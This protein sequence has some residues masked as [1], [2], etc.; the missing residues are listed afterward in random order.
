MDAIWRNPT[1]VPPPVK[2]TT[3]QIISDIPPKKRAAPPP[4]I[5]VEDVT[6]QEI[7]PN[8]ELFVQPSTVSPAALKAT[9]DS[10]SPRREALD[11]LDDLNSALDKQCT[12]TRSISDD[13]LAVH[14]HSNVPSESSQPTET[15]I[16]SSISPHSIK[17]DKTHESD[18]TR[19]PLRVDM[20]FVQGLRLLRLSRLWRASRRSCTP[21]IPKERHQSDS[22]IS[23]SENV[24]TQNAVHNCDSHQSVQEKSLVKVGIIK[25]YEQLPFMTE[26]SVSAQLS[27]VSEKPTSQQTHSLVKDYEAKQLKRGGS[28]RRSSS[29]GRVVSHSS[30]S[31]PS[32]LG[33][34]KS[35]TEPPLYYSL[36]SPVTEVLQN[37]KD[38][39]YFDQFPAG[40]S[41]E[42]GY[43]VTLTPA[44]KA[45]PPEPPVD[46]NDQQNS[47]ENA[48]PQPMVNGATVRSASQ[49]IQK[50]QDAV[51][52]AHQFV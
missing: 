3:V 42:N 23:S 27:S 49:D 36:S 25:P 35:K 17:D 32:V 30:L 19:F 41:S 9:S 10:V 4:P 37:S 11:I 44:E 20:L 51:N 31:S 34:Q 39:N 13:L 12:S 14:Q 46:Y 15:S 26:N 48:P 50:V 47:K 1:P 52:I 29:Q 6:P 5:V 16:H 33:V 18:N 43:F 8:K 7:E 28:L 22:L 21:L 2:E 24:S 45:P 40:P 38:Y